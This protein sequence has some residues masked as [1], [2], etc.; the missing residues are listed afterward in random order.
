MLG[1]SVL[2]HQKY[3]CVWVCVQEM[4]DVIVSEY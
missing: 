1:E 2:H 3:N 4:C